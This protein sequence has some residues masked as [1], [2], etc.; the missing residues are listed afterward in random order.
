MV[1]KNAK[2]LPF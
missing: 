1:Y 2:V